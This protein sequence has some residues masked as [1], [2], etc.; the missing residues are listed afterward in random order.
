MDKFEQFL[1]QQPL[2]SV[3]PDWRREILP[4]RQPTWREWL[5]PSP[6]AWATVA[7]TWLVII[8]LQL[9]THTASAAAAPNVDLA[10][11]LAEQRRIMAE[12]QPPPSPVPGPQS[13]WKHEELA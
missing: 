11:A 10:A 8:G 5:W 7:G 2:R 3:P 9:A 6:V 4:D 13:A 1:S 12:L